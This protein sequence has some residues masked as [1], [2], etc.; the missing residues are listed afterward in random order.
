MTKESYEKYWNNKGKYQKEYDIL[1]KKYVPYQGMRLTGNKQADMSIIA[2]IKM[3]KKYYR[4]YNDGDGFG[5]MHSTRVAHM[6][7]Y[8]RKFIFDEFNEKIAEDKADKAII[9]AWKATKGA[10]LPVVDEINWQI[11]SNCNFRLDASR[12]RNKNK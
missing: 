1:N 12:W 2:L 11:S 4:F 10:T 7:G 8:H 3:A 6:G 9:R 5:G